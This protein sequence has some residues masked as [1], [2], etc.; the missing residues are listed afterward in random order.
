V[1]EI[2]ETSPSPGIWQGD[3]TRRVIKA[4]LT[5]KQSCFRGEPG[6]SKLTNEAVPKCDENIICEMA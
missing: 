6:E 3:V 2:D 5:A 4:A 1:A